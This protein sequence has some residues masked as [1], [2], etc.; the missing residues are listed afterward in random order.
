MRQVDDASK[1]DVQCRGEFPLTKDQLSRTEMPGGGIPEQIIE[2]V[3]RNSIKDRQVAE[4]VRV[5]L[6]CMHPPR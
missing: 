6:R 5:R 4:F 3:V 1:N 2:Q